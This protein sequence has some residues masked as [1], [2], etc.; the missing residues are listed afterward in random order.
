MALTGCSH[1]NAINFVTNTQFGVK[2]GVDAQSIPE[3]NVGY[4]RQEAARVPVY[5]EQQEPKDGFPTSPPTV[6]SILM[7]VKARLAAQDDA[8]AKA[9]MA[10]AMKMAETDGEN[11][12]LLL[13]DINS[14]VNGTINGE[15]ERKTIMGLI[16]AEIGKIA[17]FNAFYREAK[18]E[19]EWTPTTHGNSSRDALSVLGTFSGSG[20]GSSKDGDAKVSLGQYFATGVAAQILAYRGGAA[21]VNP[22][23]QSPSDV[24]DERIEQLMD[25]GREQVRTER[26]Q[27]DEV[28]E[29]VFAVDGSG[30]PP[31]ANA[32][33]TK[34]TTLRGTSTV[35]LSGELFRYANLTTKEL[36]SDA[37]Q[38][39]P[40]VLR[41]F[42]ANLPQ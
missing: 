1:G 12:S 32:R 13:V 29:W 8:V 42:H 9:L 26:S 38:D 5:W 35:P 37:L 27:A 4:S 23:A 14:K 3:I 16:D 15:T 22:G 41:N 28:A 7:Q 10:E 31:D 20:A 2:V 33:Q 11:Q 18:F 39:N 25:M 24:T 30:T 6:H 19:G 17:T 34:L 36:L 40:E 21:T